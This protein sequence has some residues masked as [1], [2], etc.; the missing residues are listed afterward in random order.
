MENPSQ[1]GC[2]VFLRWPSVPRLGYKQLGHGETEE[3]AVKVIVGKEKREFWVDPFVLDKYPFRVLMETLRKE[4]KG[5]EF[6]KNGAIFV[7]VDEILF[8]HILWLV[9]N[10]RS[11]SAFSMVQLNLT[12]IIEFY[13]QDN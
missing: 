2:C 9:C 13:A 8:E 5:G 10:D 4:R 12:E 7:D 1:M 3:T 11:Q 6:E